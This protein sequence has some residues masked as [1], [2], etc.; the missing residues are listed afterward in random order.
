[1]EID[2]LR[3]QDELGHIFSLVAGSLLMPE[4]AIQAADV[5]V[6]IGGMGEDERVVYPRRKYW[7]PTESMNRLFLVLGYNENESTW[8]PMD[9]EAL[10]Q[11][12]FCISRTDGLHAQSKFITTLDQARWIVEKIGELDIKSLALFSAP[13]HLPRMLA[14]LIK[15]MNKRGIRV[16]VIPAPVLVSPSS[17]VPETGAGAWDMKQGEAE[18]LIAYA[19]KGDVAGIKEF[20]EYIDWL[21]QQPIVTEHL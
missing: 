18:R 4:G 10:T 14:T 12:P 20:K 1:M 7:E 17:V 8:K 19:K 13:Y 3:S 9:V 21:W 5:L 16:P 6:S 11:E 15:E 2:R